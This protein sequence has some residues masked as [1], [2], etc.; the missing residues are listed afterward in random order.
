M[1]QTAS[2]SVAREA[3]TALDRNDAGASAPTADQANVQIIR[4]LYD[5]F[6][7]RDVVALLDGMDEDVEWRIDGPAEIPFTGT[8]RGHGEVARV[9]QKSFA[10]VQD[11]QPEVRQV[12][13]EGDTV[14]VHGFER[15]THK[16]TGNPYETSWV[17]VFTL[18]DGKVVKFHEEF[19]HAP[20]LEAMRSEKTC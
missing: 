20:I 5:A 2:P 9:L 14:T 15:G 16:P 13:A 8:A 3:L 17:H 6:L 19:E 12:C 11:Q 1:T 10:T 18:R 7:R 4:Q